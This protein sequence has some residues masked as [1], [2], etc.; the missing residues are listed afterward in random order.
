MEAK[1]WDKE[2]MMLCY[3]QLIGGGDVVVQLEVAQPS[4]G[5]APV[6][7]SALLHAHKWLAAITTAS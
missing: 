5:S 7:G 6:L 1:S 4:R 2:S 3:L